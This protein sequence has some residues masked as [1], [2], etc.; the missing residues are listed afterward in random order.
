MFG[1]SLRSKRPETGLKYTEK[2]V[3]GYTPSQEK[4]LVSGA[5][6]DNQ[7]GLYEMNYMVPL[8][9]REHRPEIWQSMVNKIYDKRDKGT[10]EP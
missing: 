9:S 2:M 3:I 5:G 8:E 4:Q 6:Y 1:Y 10:L 7:M